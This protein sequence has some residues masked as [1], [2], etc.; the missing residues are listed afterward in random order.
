MSKAVAIRPYSALRERSLIAEFRRFAPDAQD[1]TEY[2]LSLQELVLV[3]KNNVLPDF[4]KRKQTNMDRNES[5][6]PFRTHVRFDFTSQ[7]L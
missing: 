7:F 2:H 6:L 4:D 3:L 5:L 1:L